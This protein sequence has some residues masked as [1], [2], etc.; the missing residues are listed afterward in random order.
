MESDG[1]HVRRVGSWAHLIRTQSHNNL[2]RELGNITYLI[3]L[4]EGEISSGFIARGGVI[5]AD[6]SLSYKKEGKQR[7]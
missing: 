2:H 1:C 6:C 3:P 5:V 4:R 7:L